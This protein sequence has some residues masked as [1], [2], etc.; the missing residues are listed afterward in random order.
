MG[1]IFVADNMGL[2]SFEILVV[3]SERHVCNVMEH[4]TLRKLRNFISTHIRSKNIVHG[5]KFLVS[6]FIGLFA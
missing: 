1:Y 6:T 5:R 4:K 3:G 2:S